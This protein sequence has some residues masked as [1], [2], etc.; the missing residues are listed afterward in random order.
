MIVNHPKVMSP[1][2]KPIPDQP[3]LTQRFELFINGWEVVNSY[4]EL[5]DPRIQK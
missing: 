5:N 3:H 2:A 4:T 1:L